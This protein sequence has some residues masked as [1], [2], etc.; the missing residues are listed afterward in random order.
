MARM[1]IA[2]VVGSAQALAARGQAGPTWWLS[3]GATRSMRSR[4][5]QG[6]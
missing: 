6:G 5:I 4:P 3:E 2:E 1:G